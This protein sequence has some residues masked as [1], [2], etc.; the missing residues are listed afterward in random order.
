[1]CFLFIGVNIGIWE[2]TVMG[3]GVVL[4]PLLNIILY[5]W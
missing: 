1:M 3:K 4:P 5:L 2:W